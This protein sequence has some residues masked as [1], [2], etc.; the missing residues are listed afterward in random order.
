[1]MQRTLGSAAAAAAYRIPLFF[2][3]TI[4][5]A[6]SDEWA[7]RKRLEQ[8]RWVLEG[9]GMPALPQKPQVV[10]AAPRGKPTR[11]WLCP[12]LAK[13]RAYATA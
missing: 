4:L 2:F 7:S 13:R 9:G 12:A 11:L 3:S 10:M 1:M 8:Q 5:A 6:G